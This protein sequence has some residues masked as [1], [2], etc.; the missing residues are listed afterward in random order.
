MKYID[1]E[2]NEQPQH[3]NSNLKETKSKSEGVIPR[4]GMGEYVPYLNLSTNQ[5]HRS[6][7]TSSRNMNDI[8]NEYLSSKRW[9]MVPNYSADSITSIRAYSPCHYAPPS[10]LGD[11]REIIK[12][13]YKTAS[14]KSTISDL[15][16]RL[17][18]YNTE[19]NVKRC[20]G[21]NYNSHSEM[22]SSSRKSS[23][24]NF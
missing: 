5:P 16:T 3:L 13:H 17:R 11:S 2:E 19:I 12:L 14:L 9:S 18:D 7:G 1:E 20:T 21:R 8:T 10:H 4:K 23:Y 22:S 24:E 15:N 6:N